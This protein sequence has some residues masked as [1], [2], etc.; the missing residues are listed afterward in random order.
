MILTRFLNHGQFDKIGERE[1]PSG[2][3]QI[4]KHETNICGGYGGRCS[5][6]LAVFAT[7][8][9]GEGRPNLTNYTQRRVRT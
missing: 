1:I 4:G 9:V 6:G 7:E 3:G 8:L 2:G 5:G